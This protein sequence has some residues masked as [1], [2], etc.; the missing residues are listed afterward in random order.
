MNIELI[1][2][3]KTDSPEVE[4]LL[5]TYAKRIN[6]YCRMAVTALADV[7]NTRNMAPATQKRACA[8]SRR[9]ITCCCSTNTARNIPP[10]SS[11]SGCRNAC[12]AASNAS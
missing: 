12:R 9:E 10:S 3:G 5:A 11:R 2:V 1:M 8:T 4:A 6:R 7:R